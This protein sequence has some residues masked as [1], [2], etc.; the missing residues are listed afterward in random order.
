MWASVLRLPPASI[1]RDQDFYDLGGDSLAAARILA[2]VRKQLGVG[3]TLDRMH[4]VK[5][6]RG[7]AMTAYVVAGTAAAGGPG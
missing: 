2:G 3:I 1:D 5:T 4:E 7:W 6:V